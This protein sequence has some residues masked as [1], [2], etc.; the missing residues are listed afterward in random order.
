[1]DK[2][3]IAILNHNYKKLLKHFPSNDDL[4]IKFTVLL[5]NLDLKLKNP[6]KIYF[7]I[8]LYCNV[9]YHYFGNRK[10]QLNYKLNFNP[11]IKCNKFKV[12]TYDE[13]KTEKLLERIVTYFNTDSQTIL[14]ITN[15][16]LQDLNN[17]KVN[18]QQT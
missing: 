18:I 14:P 12:F 17:I 15:L 4:S 6:L 1:M 13:D 10:G 2:K 3:E 9:F 8:S 5:N 7:L 16:I 11:L